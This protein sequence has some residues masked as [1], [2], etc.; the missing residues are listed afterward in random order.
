MK[1]I[2]FAFAILSFTVSSLQAQEDPA[3]A[4]KKANRAV[5]AYNLDPTN[6]ED[7]L[8]E[9][10]EAINIA[11]T[12]SEEKAMA[13]VWLKRGEIYNAMVAKEANMIYVQE[14]YQ[15]SDK[16]E[17]NAMEA[18][19]SFRKA[20]ELAEKKYESKEALDGMRESANYFNVVGNTMLQ[21]QRYNE[22]FGSL[23]AVL[24]IQQIFEKNEVEPV[25]ENP[26][27]LANHKFVTAFCANIAG[28]QDKSE[29]LFK[30]LYDGDSKEPA[31]YSTYFSLLIDKGEKDAAMQVME[32]G[33]SLFPGNTDL[34]FAEIN[35][36]LKEGKMDELVG[37]LKTAIDK[38][39]SNVS[40]YSTLGSVY[41]NL[42][43]REMEAGNEDGATTNFN[44]AL[45][46]YNKA[47]EIKPD[48]FDATYSIGALYYNKAAAYTKE[49]IELEDDYSREGLK[50]YE[51]KKAEVFSYFDDALP[52]FQEAEKMDPNDV[53]T[54][55]ALKEIYARKNDLEVSNEIKKRLDNVQNGGVN[56]S[57]YFK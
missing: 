56:E 45:E 52:F 12:G 11:V 35:F 2:L 53:N 30:D 39:P 43:Q 20:L 32:K 44:N 47:L 40:L 8:V 1:K 31:V 22:A 7:K 36:Y 57:S 33:K 6:N 13:K 29:R 37:K 4:F 14:D 24:D 16:A 46:Y 25:F 3:K 27:D 17:K 51:A 26:D 34:L 15:L 5:S 48:F 19:S 38:E 42:F 41:D 49:L 28:E 21:N 54:L 10:E 23:I 9:A 18:L 55:I 50:K